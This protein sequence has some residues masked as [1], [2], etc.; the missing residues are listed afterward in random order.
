MKIG[1]IKVGKRLLEELL[2]LPTNIHISHTIPDNLYNLSDT[3]NI[4]LTGDGL[5]YEVDEGMPIPVLTPGIVD[6]F[7]HTKII[8]NF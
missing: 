3:V 4:V 7:E 2:C 5:P 6:V 8:W 1:T